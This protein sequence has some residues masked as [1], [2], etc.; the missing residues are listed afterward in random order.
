M[1]RENDANIVLLFTRT[2]LKEHNLITK[3]HAI[4]YRKNTVK[5]TDRSI[6]LKINS[7]NIQTCCCHLRSNYLTRPHSLKI[8][9]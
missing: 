1:N 5:Q 6:L 8:E 4:H 7:S 2:L 9:N 3:V